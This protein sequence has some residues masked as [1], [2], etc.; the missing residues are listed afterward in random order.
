[1]IS[2]LLALAALMNP[3]QALTASEIKSYNCRVVVIA[4]DLLPAGSETKEFTRAAVSA[5][6]HGGT[7]TEV[8]MGDHDVS[9]LADGKW[10]A[11]SWHYKGKMVAETVTAQVNPITDNATMI[12]YN[13]QNIEEMVTL[14]CDPSAAGVFPRE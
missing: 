9:V 3:A 8:K 7:E 2:S 1:M 10:R 11:I 14:T 12:V 6:S 5:G 4:Q 13:P